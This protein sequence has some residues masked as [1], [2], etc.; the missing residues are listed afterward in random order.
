MIWNTSKLLVILIT[1]SV[2]ACNINPVEIE[3][4]SIIPCVRCGQHK[5]GFMLYRN[6]EIY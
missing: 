2:G 5:P 4:T 1:Y 6:K 3:L